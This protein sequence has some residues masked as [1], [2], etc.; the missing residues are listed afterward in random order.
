MYIH[1]KPIRTEK[2]QKLKKKLI[3][4]AKEFVL[5]LKKTLKDGISKKGKGKRTCFW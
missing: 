4:K 2:V 1:A 3:W 5:Q